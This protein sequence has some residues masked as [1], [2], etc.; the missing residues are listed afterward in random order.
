MPRIVTAPSAGIFG[1]MVSGILVLLLRGRTSIRNKRTSALLR[2]NQKIWNGSRLPTCNPFTLAT[3]SSSHNP[4]NS[5]QSEV[6]GFSGRAPNL[7]VAGWRRCFQILKAPNDFRVV[8]IGFLSPMCRWLVAAPHG[9][10][11]GWPNVKSAGS[12]F[13]SDEPLQSVRSTGKL[14]CAESTT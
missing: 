14:S 1:R 11:G 2:M 5:A 8:R 12:W 4:S 3:C 10:V 9:D 7:K 6:G 13:R